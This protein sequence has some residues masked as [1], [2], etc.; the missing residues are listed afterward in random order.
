MDMKRIGIDLLWVRPT[1]DGN[2][3][4]GGTYSYIKNILDGLS[5]THVEKYL[6][7]LYVSRDNQQFFKDYENKQQ[8][9]IKL[10]NTNSISQG[11]RILWENF[12]MNRITKKDRLDIW[13]I[14]VFSRPLL[15]S[16]KAASVTVIHDLISLHYPGNYSKI[17]AYFFWKSW[18]RDVKCSDK[19]VTISAFCKKDIIQRLK[20]ETSKVE[21]IYNPIIMKPSETDFTELQG[22]YGIEKKRYLYTVS[23]LAK[24]K[25]LLTI[26][27]ALKLFKESD[28]T[29]KLVITGVKDN[30][31]SI[32]SYIEE[33]GLKDNVI[34]TGRISDSIRDCL[35]DNCQMFLFPS[36]FEGFGMPAVEAMERN[37]PVI[38]TKET[39]LLEVTQGK[40]TYVDNPY[41][42]NEWC[43]KISS[44]VKNSNL[45]ADKDARL[46]ADFDTEPYSLLHVTNE[47][48]KLFDR[49]IKNR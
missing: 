48:L 37:I 32:L 21:V 34:Y 41:D 3:A 45:T 16:R 8:F 47:Y 24:H 11:K 5:A 7:C 31:N 6:F 33:N 1:Q 30:D 9:I 14:P 46:Y 35:Y 19:V 23:S 43:Q 40:A 13:F 20:A 10:C 49:V 4:N 17:R 25:N 22:R 28:K 36:V 38:T 18:K 2:V 39:A 44:I 12:H 15:L 27:K 42:E 26:I 29:V